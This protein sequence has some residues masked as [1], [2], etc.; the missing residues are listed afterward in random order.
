MFRSFF[1]PDEIIALAHETGFADAR[2]VS[3][4]D[5]NARY[6]SGRAD[7]LRP[8]TGKDLLVATR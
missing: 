6:F 7:G 8:P 4:A 1:T 2:D 5:Q 3:L